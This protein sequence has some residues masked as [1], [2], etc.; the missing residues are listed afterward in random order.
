M[1][2]ISGKIL[3]GT[4]F[5]LFCVSMILNTFYLVGCNDEQSDGKPRLTEAV[6]EPILNLTS[7][8]TRF[9]ELMRLY[10]RAGDIARRSITY[11]AELKA[12]GQQV[13]IIA[14]IEM[15]GYYP[16]LEIQ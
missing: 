12:I 4:F 15:R 3:T 7:P 2:P 13:Q 16:V 5:S 11:D 1:K 9:D 14:I 6:A 10:M 8:D